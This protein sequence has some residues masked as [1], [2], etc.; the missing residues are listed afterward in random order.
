MNTKLRRKSA[1]S[2]DDSLPQQEKRGQAVLKIGK[3]L[4]TLT[5]MQVQLLVY[6]L[7]KGMAATLSRQ[8]IGKHIEA[9]YHTSVVVFNK[10]FYFGQ[11]I[12]SAVPYSTDHGNPI[13]VIDMGLTHIPIDVFDEF[14]NE[15]KVIYTAEKYHLLD[16]NC[17]NF[18]NQVCFID[19]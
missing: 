16:N 13:N 10:E 2:E 1:V 3:I 6:D 7:S 15:M 8:L 17:N 9:I 18:T 11:G 5:N 12:Y 19:L 14:I 4:K